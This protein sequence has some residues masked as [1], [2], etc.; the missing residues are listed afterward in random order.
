M[1][2]L[3]YPRLHHQVAFGRAGGR[4]IWR[5]HIECWYDDKIIGGEPLPNEL[6][7]FSRT[8][9][10]RALGCPARVYDY[11]RCFEPV[12]DPR[13]VTERISRIRASRARAG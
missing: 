2:N 5:P 10:Y 13:S 11:G 3:D 7:S 9:V 1:A 4:I 8:D 6:T 12:P